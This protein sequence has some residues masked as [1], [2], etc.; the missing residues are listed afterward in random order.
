MCAWL[1]CL[2]VCIWRAIAGVQD[3]HCVPLGGPASAAAAAAAAT[4]LLLLAAV[5]TQRP[6]RK[7]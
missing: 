4:V 2:V 6:A 3:V 7:K 1:T 5:A